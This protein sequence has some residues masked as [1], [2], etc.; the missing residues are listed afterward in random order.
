MF[1][2]L[3]RKDRRMGVDVVENVLWLDC[4]KAHLAAAAADADDN[5]DD[6]LALVNVVMAQTIVIFIATIS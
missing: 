5:D 6:K 1:S 4:I 2:C 3:E